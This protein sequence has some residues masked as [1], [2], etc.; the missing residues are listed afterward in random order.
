MVFE[1]LN[2]PLCISETFW[3]LYIE[4]ILNLTP[5][6]YGKKM[7]RTNMFSSFPLSPLLWVRFIYA[8]DELL[9]IRTILLQQLINTSTII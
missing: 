6:L 9:A 2:L 7:F 5:C 1:N 4:W 3:T 8:L